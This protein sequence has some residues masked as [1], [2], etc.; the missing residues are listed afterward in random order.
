MRFV[1]CVVDVG[2]D[3]V[4]MFGLVGIDMCVWE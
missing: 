2:F 4:S 1:V 3:I